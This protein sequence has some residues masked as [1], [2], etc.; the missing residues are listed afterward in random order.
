MTTPNA[1]LGLDDALLTE[2]LGDFLD[3]SQGYL[4][5]LNTHLLELDE[6]IRGANQDSPP[7]IEAET[8]NVMFRAAPQP[9]GF[10][11]DAPTRRYQQADP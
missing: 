7:A 1:S 3:E 5:L 6:L 8:L 4:A 11:S 2:M 10:V 9:Q